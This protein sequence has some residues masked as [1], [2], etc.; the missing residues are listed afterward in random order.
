MSGNVVQRGQFAILT[1]W[2]RSQLALY[3]GADLVLELPLLASL[4]SADYFAKWSID[5]LGRLGINLL[6]FGT[7]TASSQ[8]IKDLYQW[9]QRNDSSL[10]SLVCQE[11]G[12]GLSYAASKQAAIDLMDT[13]QQVTFN[14]SLGNNLLGLKYYQWIQE[15]GLSMEIE[16]LKRND[17]FLS[18]S[19]IREI[20]TNQDS[21]V[22]YLP[23]KT[24]DIFT[25][26]NIITMEKF[27]P[28]LKYQLV[29]KNLD[30]L[31]QIQ[32]VREGIEYL[33]IDKINQVESMSDFINQLTSKR[34]TKSSI[35]RILMNILLNISADDWASYQKAY[36]KLPKIRI[37]AYNQKGRQFL[38]EQRMS[39]KV[40]LFSN[41]NKEIYQNYQL[42]IRA[43]AIYRLGNRL[44]EEQNIGKFPYYMTGL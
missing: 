32:A 15:F 16:A 25:S 5:L 29:S 21:L 28:L 20:A 6:I 36:Q 31:G 4:Q 9:L 13:N 22:D 23:Q 10:E 12:K 40:H 3:E 14:V 17:K 11:M 27:F 1:K 39:G 37:L 30:D 41:L 43:D 8:E 38:K 42:M 44:V 7:E 35:Q 33:L 2:Q 34:W 19:Q 26:E 18:G 24:L